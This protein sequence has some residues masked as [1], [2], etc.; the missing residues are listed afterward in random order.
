[1]PRRLRKQIQQSP[2]TYDLFS[3]LLIFSP[4]FLVRMTMVS[5]ANL[6]KQPDWHSPV[7]MP[8]VSPSRAP[9]LSFTHYFQAPATQAS[10]V[11]LAV[12]NR[13]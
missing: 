9:V 8:R 3:K 7:S 10:D 5:L 13:S 1:M 6:R 12:M 4:T 2:R 11:T